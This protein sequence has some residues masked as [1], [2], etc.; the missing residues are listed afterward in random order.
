[1]AE[2]V[3]MTGSPDPFA[4]SSSD[5]LPSDPAELRAFAAALLERCA[6]LERLLKLANDARHGRSS[7]KLGPDQLQLVLEDIDQTVAALEAME[8]RANP[9]TRD[10]RAAAR[11]ANRGKLPEHLP[12]VIETLMP[13]QNCCPCCKGALHEIGV[14]ESQRL[15]VVPAQYRVIVTRRPK[16]ACR[17]CFGVV[18]QHPAPERLI[19]GGLPTERLVAHVIDA[20]YHWHLPLY[21]QAQM[22]ATHGITIDR[23]TLA[24]WVGY[25]AQELAPLWH[26]LR[27]KL[28]A[29]L[30]LCVDETPAPVL[31]PGRGKTK[32]GY[33]WAIS[34]DDRPWAGPDP[35]GVVYTYAPGRGAVHGLKLLEGYHGVIHCDGYQVY[36]TMTNSA[37]A[38]TLS[39]DVT[40]AFCWSHLRR[41]FVQLERE[42]A[43]SP[44]P[45]AR[46]A[47]QRIAQ[48][49]AIE[50]ALRG[51]S[52]EERRAGRQAHAR[53][54]A[55]ALKTWFEIQLGLLSGKSETAGTL[56]YAFRHWEGLTLYLEDGRIE[57]DTNAVERAMR[58]IKLN[59][60][61]ALFAGCDVGASYCSSGDVLIRQ[62]TFG[63]DFERSGAVAASR[64][65]PGERHPV[66]RR[67]AGLSTA[68]QST[69]AVLEARRS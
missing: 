40:L 38:D 46:E 31:D 27:E 44:A 7:E 52:A 50:K 9:A 54:L 4:E 58:P 69:A 19:K 68:L 23:S 25:A 2:S 63:A 12:R 48:L 36:K 62:G 67:Q 64:R 14:D 41:Q 57:M 53:P 60:K 39:A 16:L 55:E 66:A 59:A 24:F 18:V 61:N 13:T 35:P 65:R 6:R 32:T 26:R 33:F 3:A 51:R 49:Y 20:K 21:R 17:A 8:D 28:L 37:R 42:A 29:S 43:P 1:M 47:L 45:I 11:R 5:V 56:R 22:M 30:K 34:R 15:D 10:K